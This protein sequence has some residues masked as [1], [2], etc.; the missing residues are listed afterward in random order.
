MA[1]KLELGNEGGEKLISK[2]S[3]DKKITLSLGQSIVIARN[4]GQT[5]N[6]L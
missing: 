3:S 5:N 2:R 4:D 1:L 6:G